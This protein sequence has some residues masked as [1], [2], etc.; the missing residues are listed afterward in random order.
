MRRSPVPLG[1][2]ILAVAVSVLG[3]K[4]SRDYR[5][6]KEDLQFVSPELQ[7]SGPLQMGWWFLTSYFETVV[8]P[9]VGSP[10]AP[11][12]R[13]EP[14]PVHVSVH[15]VGD[16]RV[17]IDDTLL[18][19]DRVADELRRRAPSG[20][21]LTVDIHSPGTSFNDVRRV[22]EQIPPGSEVNVRQD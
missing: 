9:P 8:P 2:L 12:S 5:R 6:F 14:T 16:G 3:I 7:P 18:P 1:W 21:P 22:M 10:S 11:Q 13:A 4:A 20:R 15:L 17:R 19:M